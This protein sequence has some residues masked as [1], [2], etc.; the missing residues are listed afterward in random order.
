MRKFSFLLVAA[1]SMLCHC[2][3]GQS[4]YR[5][6]VIY[7][8]RAGAN[9]SWIEELKTTIISESF[10]INYTMPKEK[11]FG[12]T[13]GLFLNYRPQDVPN[14]GFQAELFYSQQGSNLKFNNFQTDFHYKMEFKYQY[15][16]LA[17]LFKCYPVN[18]GQGMS[19]LS[20][21]A[22]YQVGLNITPDNIVY[23]SGGSGRQAAF[24][25]DLE[26]QQQLRNVLKGKTSAGLIGS[27]AFE[28][29]SFPLLFDAR[30]FHGLSDVVETEPNSYNFI[31]NKNTNH[32]YQV[33]LGFYL[34]RNR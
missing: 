16:N 25:S 7:G 1:A 8:L 2:A 28:L 11:R 3:K 6:N 4:Q 15:I 10:F 31:E 9:Y 5:D 18:Y 32:Y 19:G 27:I 23:T 20:L 33:T 21:G 12:G 13:A 14:V 29:P 26:Q 34:P 30:Y 24:G 22:G 17:G